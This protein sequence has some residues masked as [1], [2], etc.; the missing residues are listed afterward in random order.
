VA[1]RSDANLR[2]DDILRRSVRILEG[3]V[4]RGSVNRKLILTL[5]ALVSGFIAFYYFGMCFRS[6]DYHDGRYH[7]IPR[8]RYALSSFIAL[9]LAIVC[10]RARRGPGST[11]GAT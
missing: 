6:V 8:G 5:V 2:A 4:G 10:W 11:G 3:Y 7:D 9:V 1:R